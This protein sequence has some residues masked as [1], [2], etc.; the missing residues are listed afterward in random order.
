[1]I[2]VRD[3]H[4]SYG[5]TAAVRGLSFAVGPGRICGLLGPDGAGKTTAMR[6]VCGLLAPDGGTATVLGHDC[7]REA[8][9]IKPL[10]GYMPQRFSL[11][12][13]LT[14]AENLRFFADL[15][16]VDRRERTR[17]EAELMAFSKLGPFR[18]RRAGQLSGGMKQKLALSCTLIHTPAVLVLDE[19]TTGVDPV[20]RREFWRILRD[21]A[22]RGLALLVSTPYLDEAGLCDEIVLVHGGRA[23]ASGAPAAVATTFP[24]RLLEVRGREL[25]AAI[26]RLQDAPLAGV[27]ARRYGDRLHLVHDDDGQAAAARARLAG[28]AVEVAPVAPG[29]EDVFVALLE[30]A[31]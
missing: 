8:H 22:D 29:I 4:K 30:D 24:H 9:R 28:L 7:A 1:V 11:Y 20:S 12:P 31:P 21:L 5:L 10:L 3:L 18:D 23:V 25:P 2:T 17:R 19:P 6:I 15:F 26:A 14:V 27:A 16:A 13:D